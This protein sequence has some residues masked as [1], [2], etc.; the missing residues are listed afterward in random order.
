[1][2]AWAANDIKVE[3]PKHLE[4]WATFR[5]SVKRGLNKILADGE[6]GQVVGAFTSGG[7]ISAAMGHILGMTDEVRIIELNGLV[8]NVSISEFLFTKDKLTL[9][10]FNTIPHL[11]D[12]KLITYV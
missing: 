11:T 7:T 1:M 8:Y 9:K 2:E 12:E 3:H 6:K 10:A 5:G 4:N